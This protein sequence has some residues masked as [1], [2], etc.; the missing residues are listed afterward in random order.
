[1]SERLARTRKLVILAAAITA[2]SAAL[3]SGFRPDL[4]NRRDQAASAPLR[5]VAAWRRPGAPPLARQQAIR[6][7][8]AAS[9][10][11]PPL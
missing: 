1:M 3:F 9:L 2:R 10:R 7:D 5:E 6:R 8:C 11:G 4:M